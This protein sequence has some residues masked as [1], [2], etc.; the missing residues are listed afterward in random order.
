MPVNAGNADVKGIELE[1]TLHPTDGLSI[2]SSLSYLD[3]KY[4]KFGT[5]TSGATTV[6]VGGP[7]NLNGPQFGDY[8]PFTPKW[9][10][11]VGAQYE[12]DLGT[13]GSLTPRFDATYQS[14]VY[15][16]SANRPSNRIASYT[17]ANAR[18]TWR[19]DG[20]DLDVSLEV[21]NLFDKYYLLTIFDQTVGGQGYATGQPGRP[22]E[23]AI[24]LKKKF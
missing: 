6:S 4:K 15:T 18:I 11:S 19:N 10:W 13:S 9:K 3:F 20:K 8:A 14:T 7:T 12:I 21:T 2:D 17:L 16:V 1:A 24:T 23:W 5:F 22:Q